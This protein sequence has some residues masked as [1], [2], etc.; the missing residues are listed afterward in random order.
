VYS[1]QR[2]EAVQFF[3]HLKW[4][5]QLEWVAQQQVVVIEQTSVQLVEAAPLTGFP[6]EG[7]T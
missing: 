5:L 1:A 6:N 3:Q 2:A 4:V 7:G